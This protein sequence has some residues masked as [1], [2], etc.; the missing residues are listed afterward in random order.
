VQGTGVGGAAMR[1]TVAPAGEWVRLAV[2]AAGFPRGARC[3]LIIVT[4]DGQRE[5]AG[6]WTAPAAGRP[7]G[8]VSVSGSAAVP[9]SQVRAVA[10][11]TDGGQ[12]L[13]YLQV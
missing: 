8:G 12:E 4:A 13:M 10:V 2:T 1:A 6:S 7:E 11:E 3:R 9:M 5:Q